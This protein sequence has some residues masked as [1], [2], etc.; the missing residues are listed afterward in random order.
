MPAIIK[1]EL[2]RDGQDEQRAGKR[3]KVKG[4][5]GGS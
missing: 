4:E 3:G 1:A 2:N 5:K